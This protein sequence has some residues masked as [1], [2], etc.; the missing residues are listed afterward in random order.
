M[1]AIAMSMACS[2][3][4][5][6][7]EGGVHPDWKT[8]PISAPKFRQRLSEQM[9]TYKPY[10]KMYPGDEGMCASTQL[11]IIQRRQRNE[12]A[13]IKCK[14]NIRRVPYEQYASV[15][16][17]QRRGPKPRLCSNNMQLLKEHLRRMK[18]MHKSTC[19]M[20]GKVTYMRCMICDMQICWKEEKG[21]TTC[22]IDFH[23]DEMYGLGLL[24]HFELF[25]VLKSNFH[26]PNA[27]EIKW[28]RVHM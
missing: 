18:K 27:K 7:C 9:V 20:C 19:Q 16:A 23:D 13:T 11:S 12:S 3:Y 24:D 22:S 1:E 15:K 5:Q 14:D 6:C 26:P 25:G 10:N 4:E 28:N 8:E 21:S 17:P 2:I